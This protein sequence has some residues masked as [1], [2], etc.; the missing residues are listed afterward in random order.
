VIILKDNKKQMSGQ[1]DHDCMNCGSMHMSPCLAL[2]EIVM[3]CGSDGL[4]HGLGAI[5]P[6]GA[7]YD[8]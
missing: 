2:G 5:V 8:K 1:C 3:N 7:P 6:E 4:N